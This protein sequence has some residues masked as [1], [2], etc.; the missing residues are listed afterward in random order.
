MR[1]LKIESKVVR[2]S[3]RGTFG[4]GVRLSNGVPKMI[5]GSE[6]RCFALNHGAN[7]SVIPARVAAAREESRIPR[8]ITVGPNPAI[9]GS[10]IRISLIFCR[11]VIRFISF[12]R[13]I[14]WLISA[15]SS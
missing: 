3:H 6:E 15:K 5:L 2:S 12:S 9:R 8:R 4:G 1:L 14:A 7:G 10:S 11:R 13:A